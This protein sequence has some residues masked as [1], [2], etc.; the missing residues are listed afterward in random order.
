MAKLI[1]IL[2]CLSLLGTSTFAWN[3]AGH[4]VS[5]AIAYQTLKAEHPNSLKKVMALFKQHPEYQK[6][7]STV[8]SLS[9][10][11][12]N[13][14]LYIFMLAAKWAD[15]IRDNP[16]FNRPKWHYINY[17]LAFDNTTVREPDPE[18]IVSA[19]QQVLLNDIKAGLSDAD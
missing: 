3:R 2:L 5:G 14:D 4:M 11:T 7:E 18:N 15:D 12:E 13:H 10:A 9:E 1:R 8:Q 6:C 17:P 19:F 16:T